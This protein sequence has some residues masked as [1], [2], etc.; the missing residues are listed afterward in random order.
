MPEPTPEKESR[1][2]TAGEWRRLFLAALRSSGNVRASCQA[3][4]INRRT[5]YDHRDRS[6]VFRQ[7]WDE[8]LADAIDVLEAVAWQRARAVSDTLLIFLL[9]AHRP[10]L[11]RDTVNIELA[12][13]QAAA[14]A[15]LDPDAAVIEARAIVKEAKAAIV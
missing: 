12:I 15:G 8:A 2:R 9:K 11:Y 6:L 5:A 14:D 4:G 1:R 13:R 7:Q 3:A 10:G